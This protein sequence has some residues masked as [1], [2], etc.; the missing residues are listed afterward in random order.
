MALDFES[1][2]YLYNIRLRAIFKDDEFPTRLE[3]DIND[4]TVYNFY[5]ENVF[6]IVQIELFIDRE[7][8]KKI[9]L[10]ADTIKFSLSV[11][12]YQS[13][14]TIAE[15]SLANPTIYQSFIDDKILIPYDIDRTILP[16]INKSENDQEERNDKQFP[17]ILNCFLEEH[18]LLNK[19][20]LSYV[21]HKADIKSTILYALN[22]CK[23]KNILFSE[24]DNNKLYEQILIP[25]LNLSNTIDY[26]QEVYG[27]Y[28]SGL[29]LFFDMKYNYLINKD[30][31]KNPP[32]PKGN[33]NEF[34]KVLL[35]LMDTTE[36]SLD[37]YGSFID[38]ENELYK[39]KLEDRSEFATQDTSIR[40]IGGEAIKFLSR[41]KSNP[42]VQRI[43]DLRHNVSNDSTLKV[44]NS[45]IIKEN[46]VWNNYDNPYIESSY[47]SE[48]SRRMLK[49][50]VPWEDID[51]DLF[52]LNKRYEITFPSSEMRSVY[53]GPYQLNSLVY[54]FN[55]GNKERDYRCF[56][57]C[58]FD[59]LNLEYI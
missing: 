28:S 25:P 4:L 32:I 47:K 20:L 39:I 34:S 52:T 50:R 37:D 10:N 23:A 9:Q 48:M 31:K 1:R 27:I 16:L 35:M 54:K 12:K 19:H 14:D 57:V 8:F 45:D 13:D 7:M 5:E 33:I 36:N 2:K 43:Q 51:L 3:A 56:G 38:T 29:N 6:P 55:K 49:L 15:N 44:T 26:L 30:Y 22:K 53:N 46:I 18:V 24:P 58:M 21:T 11:L 40:E 59:K 17:L 42:N 41:T